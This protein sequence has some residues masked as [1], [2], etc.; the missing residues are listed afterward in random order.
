MSA[1]C[2]NYMQRHG[3]SS[4]DD[5]V[6][7]VLGAL[8][9]LEGHL[10]S[11]VDRSSPRHEFDQGQA[12]S[13]NPHRN[14]SNNR[15]TPAGGPNSGGIAEEQR[16]DLYSN[17]EENRT[18]Q[19]STMHLI[20]CMETWSWRRGRLRS[21]IQLHEDIV[22]SV[23]DD[24]QLFQLLRVNYDARKGGLFWRLVSPRTLKSINFMKVSVLS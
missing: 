13:A 19:S 9:A 8:D 23:P 12:A 15:S 2:S 1:D 10:R 6:E 18:P 22:T 3:K 24:C 5:Y 4:Y 20:S 16:E 11:S 14:R 21:R 7:H 17:G